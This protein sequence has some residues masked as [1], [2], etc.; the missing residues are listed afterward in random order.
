M[1][2]R[3]IHLAFAV[4]AVAFGALAAAQAIQLRKA[5]RINQAVA[6]AKANASAA[7]DVPEARL[8]QAGA[9]AE[10]GQHD[11]ALAV[12]N[13]LIQ[14]GRTD[15]LGQAALFN[16]G[17][18]FLRN[19]RETAANDA[20]QAQALVELAKQRY[21]DLLRADP[22]DWDARY[23]LERALWLAPE[24]QDVF[25]AE[26]DDMPKELLRIKVPGLPPGDL[27]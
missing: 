9:L 12:Y 4:A 3:T 25:G 15:A 7:A 20:F 26:T 14:R 6:S 18:M 22:G 23:N 16:L 17:N 1:R 24:A 2:R 8:A 13:S 10:A 21:R 27:P 11:A 5:A 19:A